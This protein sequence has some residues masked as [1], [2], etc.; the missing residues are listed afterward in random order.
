MRARVTPRLLCAGALVVVLGGCATAS[1]PL[2]YRLPSPA[3]VTY[4]A[5]DTLSIEINALGQ[6][7][8]LS[9]R[10][11]ASYAIAFT[12]AEDGVGARLT[13]TDLQ[14]DVSLPGTAPMSVGEEIVQGDLVLALSPRGDVTIV[15]APEV[16]EAASAFLAGPTIAHSF[17]PGLPGTA[18]RAGDV[19]V[20]TVSYAEDGDTGDASQQS[21]TTYTVVGQSV[22]DGRPLLEI[23]LEGTQEMQ[24]T[25]SFQGVDVEQHT[26][27]EVTGRVLWDLQRGLMYE[28]ETVSTGTGTVRVAIAPTPLPTQVEIR[29]RAR[30]VDR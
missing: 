23:T 25:M 5:G 11:T 24:Q 14:A 28:R 27:L 7:L 26:N 21:I 4:A 6:R 13:V 9:V 19:W 2:A 17:F 16:E 10:T 1:P 15:E 12:P 3:E 8:E 18:A 30:L 29:S 20:D 22:V